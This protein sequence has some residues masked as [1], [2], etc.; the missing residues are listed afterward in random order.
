MSQQGKYPTAGRAF[1]ARAIEEMAQGDLAQAS[2]KGW[3]AAAQMVKA[4]AEKRG[5][6]HDGHAALFQA[7]RQL[8]DETGDNQVVRLFHIANSLHVNFYEN[9]IPARSVQEGLAAIQEFVEKL[10]DALR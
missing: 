6:P 2:E 1:L 4:V 5:W 10:E 8:A 7:V 3:G 9:W